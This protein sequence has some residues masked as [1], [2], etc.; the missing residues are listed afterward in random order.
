MSF[1]APSKDLTALKQIDLLYEY[2]LRLDYPS[3]RNF[4]IA[5]V[6]LSSLCQSNSRL[7]RL[8]EQKRLEYKTDSLLK[9]WW[10]SPEHAFHEA[11]KQGDVGIVDELIKRGMDPSKGLK[12]TYLE[13]SFLEWASY[14]G[15]LSVVNRLLED[16]RVNPASNSKGAIGWASNNGHLNVVNRLLQDPRTDP[17]YGAIQAASGKGY[18]DIVDR[19]LQDPRVDPKHSIIEAIDAGRV[20]IINRLLQDQRVDPTYGDNYAIELASKEDKRGVVRRL[21]QDIRVRHSLPPD[22]LQKYLKQVGWIFP[23]PTKSQ[24]G[25]SNPVLPSETPSRIISSSRLPP[26]SSKFPPPSAI[27][28]P[29]NPPPS[30][31]LPPPHPP[32]PIRM[33]QLAPPGT[34][35]PPPLQ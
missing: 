31:R 10:G 13:L 21:L 8:I 14:Y 30:S 25:F 23:P 32:H 27:R 1:Q 20:I 7:T 3:I 22:E 29:F 33:G 6:E 15:Q 16:E 26:P 34:K 28:P 9:R 5:D 12:L 19:L 24:Q 4:C 11:I 18:L 2:F 17:T 35:L